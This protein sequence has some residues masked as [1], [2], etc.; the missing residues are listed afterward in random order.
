MIYVPTPTVIHTYTRT[1]TSLRAHV[2]PPPIH[3]HACTPTGI[4]AELLH[5]TGNSVPV[6]GMSLWEL[7]HPA[8]RAVLAGAEGRFYATHVPADTPVVAPGRRESVVFTRKPDDTAS[9]T[10]S[11][12]AESLAFSAA[13][14]SHLSHRALPNGA[15]IGDDEL[16]SYHSHH[17][18]F[19]QND[20]LQ[21]AASEQRALFG[22]AGDEFDDSADVCRRAEW[23]A[24]MRF[25]SEMYCVYLQGTV[26]CVVTG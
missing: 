15:L 14:G 3:T 12:G 2:H 13:G 26:L 24:R 1:H 23:N 18:L 19:S 10:S 25:C 4:V 6:I 20:D 9:Y 7:L 17:V 16:C 8:L 22:I 21:R 5:S 11:G